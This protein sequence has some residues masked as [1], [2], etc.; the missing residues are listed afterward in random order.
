MPS[1]GHEAYQDFTRS[2]IRSHLAEPDISDA[3]VHLDDVLMVLMQLDLEPARA[4]LDRGYSPRRRGSKPYDPVVMLRLLILSVLIGE[5]GINRLVPAVRHSRVLKVLAGFRPLEDGTWPSPSV[6]T[7]YDFL[8]RLH[9]GPLRLRADAV[10]PSKLE[11]ERSRSPRSKLKTEEPEAT[12]STTSSK[13]KTGRVK[14]TRPKADEKVTAVFRRTLQGI[15]KQAL[16]DDLITR[17]LEVLQSVAVGPSMQ[18]GLLGDIQKLTIAADGS[19][20][21]TNANGHGKK[22]KTCSHGKFKRCDC[23]RTYADPDATSGWDHY[24]EKYYYGHSFYEIVGLGPNTELPLFISLAPAATN[25]QVAAMKALAR[26]VPFYRSLPDPVGIR[27]GIF[28]KGHDGEPMSRFLYEDLG[29]IPIIPIGSGVPSCHPQRPDLPLATDDATPLC[30][31]CHKMAAWGSA[32]EGHPIFV[33]PVAAGKLESC[34][35]APDDDPEWRCR[36]DLKIGPTIVLN[37]HDNP[38]LFPPMARN[39]K[40][41][42]ENYSRR[43]SC[44]RSNAYKKGPGRLEAC[45]HRRASFWLIRLYIIAIVQHARA[46]TASMNA[47]SFLADFLGVPIGVAAA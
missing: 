16:P 22:V 8:H 15:L 19:P 46:W 26:I 30:P 13:K 9:D 32:G 7:T 27:T 40:Y 42:K 25:D 28:D 21:P 31:A 2:W 18:R 6:G 38:R 37:S 17:M 1:P 29:I 39:S 45:G 34:G 44:E 10:A 35:K 4:I 33:C 41:F 36:P 20:L 43:T 47:R 11:R 12:E 5:P 3:V 23:H 14:P 24:R